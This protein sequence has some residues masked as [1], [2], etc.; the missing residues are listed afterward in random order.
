MQTV[1]ETITKIV[2]RDSDVMDH[3]IRNCKEEFC[4]IFGAEVLEIF[5]RSEEEIE[6][7][8]EVAD[9]VEKYIAQLAVRNV[10]FCAKL[11]ENSKEELKNLITAVQEHNITITLE[12][13]KLQIKLIGEKEK[14]DEIYDQFKCN[15][16]D[17]EEAL[18]V[19]T[20]SINIPGNKLELLLLHG[21]GDILEN[22]FHVDVKIEPQKAIVTFKGK[23]K[24][25]SQAKQETYKIIAQIGEDN[26]RLNAIEGRFLRSGGLDMINKGMRE[27]GLKGMVSLDSNTS[28]AKVLV[29]DNVNIEKIHS[30]LS[31]N[32]HKKQYFLD[33]D[34][35]TLLRSNKWKEF[36]ETTTTNISVKI[37][38]D[39]SSSNEI[40]LI[41]KK[42]EVEDTY[43][44]VN[45]F[46]KRNTIIRYD[47]ELTDGHVGYLAK[48]CSGALEE[49]EEKLEEQSV[50]VHLV[51][52]EATI[53]ISGTKEGVEK[54]KYQ[55]N[56][57]V[58]KIA[59]GTM[60]VDKPRMQEYLESEEGK[61]FI[62][63]IESKHKCFIF[64][65]KSDS[66]QSTVIPSIRSKP[67]LE[68]LCSYE[69][70]E[71]VVMK[72]YKGD[73]TVHCCDVIVNA[74]NGDLNHIGGLAKS[75]STA[76]G[77]EIQEECD[78]YVKAEGR[79]Y[80]GECFSGSPG[81]LPCK[82]LIHAVGPR[83]DDSKRD[84]ICKTLRVTCTRVLEEAK[85]YR[86]IALP[87]IGSGIYGIPKDVCADIMIDAA[88]EFSKTCDDC[89][90][91]EIHFVNNDD[92]SGQ[93]FVKKF[94]A[95]FGSQTSSKQKDQKVG[96]TRN[97]FSP[98]E[99]RFQND[100]SDRE[101]PEVAAEVLPRQSGDNFIIKGSMKIIVAV[102]DLS[103]YKVKPF[104]M[105]C[106]KTN[107]K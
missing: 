5:I 92:E 81:K 3:V 24:Q 93:A 60:V 35:I 26:F 94:H 42:T 104:V 72:V 78:A 13:E 61:L 89:L 15:V 25:I 74:A 43:E 17:M 58:S 31:G 105:S 46:M 6:L 21:V 18:D 38:T 67:A 57:I 52:D 70:Q 62:G 10:P 14:V 30:Y 107:S 82:R 69:T 44:K 63:G 73:M 32:M 37:Y 102:G 20:D 65:T 76:G 45:E 77:E 87:A 2:K 9:E 100:E 106:L 7:P 97:R 8:T 99:S 4:G 1:A 91:K 55:L 71:K 101:E 23:P 83:W 90:L 22:D 48:Y 84:K 34:S 103:T 19:A 39:E 68:L 53:N 56:N 79:L 41:G 27:I 98:L 54:A 86:S 36:H 66:G 49:I 47:I 64:Q 85:I 88:E 12:E 28:K 40:S 59:K 75:L 51:E 80:E 29:F 33:K 50:R 95:K 11:L 96:G 16:S